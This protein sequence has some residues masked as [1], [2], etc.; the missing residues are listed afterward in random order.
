[1]LALPCPLVPC[2][3]QRVHCWVCSVHLF[4][5]QEPTWFCLAGIGSPDLHLLPQATAATLSSLSPL[6]GG[7]ERTA[8]SKKC[9]TIWLYLDQ[10]QGLGSPG[11]SFS[12][13][14]TCLVCAGIA[15]CPQVPRGDTGTMSVLGRGLEWHC[16]S[17]GGGVRSG[18]DLPGKLW[19]GGGALCPLQVLWEG[20]R[21]E[22]APHSPPAGVPVKFPLWLLSQ[23]HRVAELEKPCVSLGLEEPLGC[24]SWGGGTCS[25]VQRGCAG[26]V[27]GPPPAPMEGQDHGQGGSRDP[28]SSLFLVA[29]GAGA[30]MDC[31]DGLPDSRLS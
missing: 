28:Q 29:T 20:E 4:V 19:Q 7:E 13:R 17:Q 2:D 25:S 22:L 16:G 1:M 5:P 6:P 30:G 10:G 3:R 12:P 18:E 26:R 31:R 23:V 24:R 8:K 9:L 15:E 21:P 11:P 14:G 27:S